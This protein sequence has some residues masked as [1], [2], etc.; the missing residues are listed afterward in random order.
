MHRRIIRV[1]VHTVRRICV[2]YISGLTQHQTI[3]HEDIC[4]VPADQPML[5]ELVHVSGL[6][7][8]ILRHAAVIVILH[9]G[10]RALFLG[11]LEAERFHVDRLDLHHL[12]AQLLEVPGRQLS[13]LVIR[14]PVRLN[15]LRREITRDCHR[16]GIKMQLL[17]GH[18]SRMSGDDHA[19]FINHD[20]LLKS[21]LPDARSHRIDGVLI[22]PRIIMIRHDLEYAFLYDIHQPTL[23]SPTFQVFFPTIPSCSSL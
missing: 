15:L 21:E 14:Q 3:D 17:R 9:D 23:S 2:Y 18:V 5:S 7:P 8:R 12:E 13:G 19:L 1:E 20:R 4:T 11:N 22:A 6:R 16:H 10:R